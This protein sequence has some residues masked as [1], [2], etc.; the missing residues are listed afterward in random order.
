MRQACAFTLVEVVVSIAIA[1]VIFSAVLLAYIGAARYAEWSGYSLAAEALNVQQLEQM[2]CAKW[3]TE[4]TPDV[5][6]TTNLNLT[7]WSF[8]NGVY[9]GYTNSML[10]MPI[11]GTNVVRATN[12][13]WMTNVMISA[14]PPVWIKH[15]R[16]STEWA[17][18]GERFT[19]TIA[20]IMGPDR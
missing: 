6:E 8:S 18:R 12:R 5:D 17:F 11:T 15:I 7:A 2:K 19:N 1:G 3:D 4:A 16:V 13:L 9:K 14:N 10:D 20:T